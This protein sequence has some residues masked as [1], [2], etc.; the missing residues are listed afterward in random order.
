MTISSLR[1]DT[2]GRVV[3]DVHSGLHS[4]VHSKVI[5]ISSV[6]EVINAVEYAR[7]K[8]LAVAIAGGRHAMGGQQLVH[9]GLLLDMTGLNRVLFIDEDRG[10][11]KVEAGIMWDDLIAAMATS[12]WSIIQKPT[13]ADRISVGG[14][15][16]ANIHGRV[17]GRG[18]FVEDIESLEVV[19]AR[20]CLRSVNRG[21]ELFSY[22]VGGYGLF[23]I[24][25][26]VTLR[27]QRKHYL[28]RRVRAAS[29][30]ELV[31]SMRSL[32]KDGHEYGDFQFNID[33]HSRQFLTEGILAS[34]E[35]A[36]PDASP[37]ESSQ[38]VLSETQWKELLSLAHTDKAE[39]F[40]RYLA[41]YLATE[42]QVYA[43][44]TMQYST[45]L[46]G[47]HRELDKE[48]GKPRG[49][50]V[51]TELY[52]PP[53]RLLRFMEDCRELFIREDADLIYGTIR[54][55]RADHTSYLAWAKNDYACIIFNL[56]TE[57]S[58]EGQFK[59]ASIF[60]RLIKIARRHQ[61]SFYLTYHRYADR[62]DLDACYP[63]FA[64]FLKKKLEL[65]PEETFQS[66]WYRHY[67]D[68]YRD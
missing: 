67:R 4:V 47:Y 31:E 54:M 3:G 66:Q 30:A 24:V 15:V 40:R 56:H 18:P 38:K 58:A 53:E 26:T 65:D 59:N 43:C 63:R 39:A 55:I 17:L 16:S 8:A 10:L 21:D 52:V 14:S 36:G 32:L 68:L 34:Y 50:E 29:L 35:P 51:I 2:A 9:D 57:H 46:D 1:A 7:I 23:G 12:S 37:R 62:E 13:G 25:V 42:G 11:L 28:R 64:G 33:N 27:L 45:Y 6:E 5:K 19:D 20:G 61:G 48:L 49:T 60:R 44:D 41:H 22:V